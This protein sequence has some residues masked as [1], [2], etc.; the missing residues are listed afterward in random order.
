MK[1]R[2]NRIKNYN[3][4]I[5]L[6]TIKFIIVTTK[7]IESIAIY[8]SQFISNLGYPVQISYTLTTQDCYNSTNS[9]IYII[10]HTDTNHGLFP[11]K[12]IVFQV[13][14]TSSPWF[15]ES[16]LTMLSKS[17]MVWDFS[18]KNIEAYK[19]IVPKDR[20]F[21]NP[22]PFLPIDFDDNEST[23]Y[24]LFFYGV[25]NERRERI[26]NE[27]A[28]DFK[29]L[30]VGFRVYGIDRDECIKK[31]KIILNLHYYSDA[32]LETCRINE[33]LNYNKIIISEYPSQQDSYNIELY[34]N[35][36]VF[37]DEITTDLTNINLLIET[38][39]FYLDKQHYIEYIQSIKKHKT[40][41]VQKIKELQYKNLQRIIP[42]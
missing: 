25:A 24:D 16:Y 29:N 7:V 35:L 26:L 34:K 14:Q 20:I 3:V 17:W 2:L 22:M 41:L 28:K 8:L 11:K 32:A 31:S 42:L 5:P 10:I 36:V 30:K 33:I 39:N 4:N 9:D 27:L 21:Y 37:V 19:H 15:T 12:F 38:I 6:I 23:E 40:V 1:T 18:L 13:E